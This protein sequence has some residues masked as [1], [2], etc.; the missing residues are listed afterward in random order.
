MLSVA[1]PI[2]RVSFEQFA[3]ETLEPKL[4]P[5]ARRL[6]TDIAARVAAICT[7]CKI[8]WIFGRIRNHTTVVLK[9]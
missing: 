6:L 5:S 1:T 7:V 4:R 8:I 9:N 3:Q 2:D